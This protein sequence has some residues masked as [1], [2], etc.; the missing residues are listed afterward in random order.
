MARNFS[1]LPAEIRLCIYEYVFSSDDQPEEIELTDAIPN[2]PETAL[3][4]T[5]KAILNEAQPTYA[6]SAAQYRDRTFKI[7]LDPARE[8]RQDYIKL[9]KLYGKLPIPVY[10]RSLKFAWKDSTAFVHFEMWEKQKLGI[11]KRDGVCALSQMFRRRNGRVWRGLIEQ[12]NASPYV[13][14]LKGPRNYGLD[15]CALMTFILFVGMSETDP[16]G[17]ETLQKILRASRSLKWKRTWARHLYCEARNR[18]AL[19]E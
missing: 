3:L 5:C 6:K 14:Q 10:V 12:M 1:N 15:V 13:Y 8:K 11:A 18:S 7:T 9:V 19:Q 2:Q 17:G 4:R 16:K